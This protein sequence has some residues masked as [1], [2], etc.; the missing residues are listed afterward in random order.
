MI[1]DMVEAV[2]QARK[3]IRRGIGSREISE[4]I[5]TLPH[6]SIVSRAVRT[7]PE[8]ELEAAKLFALPEPIRVVGVAS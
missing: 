7:T 6:D 8:V 5:G 2:P 3:E 1:I 4:K